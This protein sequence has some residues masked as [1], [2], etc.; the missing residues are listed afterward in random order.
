MNLR[1]LPTA[2]I[3]VCLL[4]VWRFVGAGTNAS[5]EEARKIILFRQ[6]GHEFLLSAG[7]STSRVLPVRKISST[8]YRLEFENPFA[9]EPDSLVRV[10]ERIMKRSPVQVKYIVNVIDCKNHEVVYGFTGPE[11]DAGTIPCTGRVLPKDRYS[12]NIL[13]SAE[14]VSLLSGVKPAW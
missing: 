7:D 2:G 13:L 6:V 4:L 3:V 14:P 1:L 11:Q 9:F 12:I 5:F 8:E 10:V